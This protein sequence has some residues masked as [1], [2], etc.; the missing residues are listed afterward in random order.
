MKRRSALQ[1]GGSLLLATTAGC[2]LPKASSSSGIEISEITLRNRL[3]RDVRASVLLIDGDEI[4]LWR[5]VTASPAPNQFVTFD[6]L[7]A[8]TGEYILYAH[9]PKTDT[10]DAVRADLVEDA[11]GQSCIEITLEITTNQPNG[12]GD[13][14][15]IYGSIGECDSQN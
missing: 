9:I 1:L 13:P 10:G 7:P 2:S 8:E 12:S 5:T 3:A 14:R 4:V 6:E 11:D 15:I